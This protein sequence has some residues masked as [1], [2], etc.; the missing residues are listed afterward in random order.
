MATRSV[1][2]ALAACLLGVVGALAF[3]VVDADQAK[4]GATGTAPGTYTEQPGY[5]ALNNTGTTL[6]VTT[7]AQGDIMLVMAHT[8]PS[9]GLSHVTSITDSGARIAWHSAKSAGYTNHPSGDA[10]EIWYGIVDS[11]G[12]TTIQAHWSGTTF[13][14]FVWAAE[15]AAPNVSDSWSVVSG[16]GQNAPVCPG[17]TCPYPSLTSGPAGGL[18]WGWAYGSSEGEAGNT[19][20]FNYFVTTDPTHWNVL[21]SGASLA[22]ST[23]YAPDFR[24]ATANGWYDAVAVI[25]EATPA[26]SGSTGTTTTTAPTT[27]TTTAPPA[28]TTT[29][30]PKTTTTTAPPATTTTTAPKTTTTTTTAPKTTTTT[31]APKTTTT[32]TTAP[33]TTTTTTAPKTTTTTAP[34]TTTTTTTFRRHHRR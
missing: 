26:T 6:P 17:V 27:T 10:L 19:P 29:T 30:A 34:K 33:K 21:I 5:P 1:R 14:H 25:V 9:A 16:G 7:V 4:V 20:G 13:D 12:P 8:A 24:Q 23:V 28:T 2:I 31:T 15:W 22:A 11:V 32:T 18:Y 3:L